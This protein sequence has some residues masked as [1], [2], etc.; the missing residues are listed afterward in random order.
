MQ[1]VFDDLRRCA[2]RIFELQCTRLVP[3]RAFGKRQ[4]RSIHEGIQ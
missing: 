4:K 3:E 1:R 2:R